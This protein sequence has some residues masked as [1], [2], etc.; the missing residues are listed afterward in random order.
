MLIHV[1]NFTEKAIQALNYINPCLKFPLDIQPNIFNDVDIRTLYWPTHC[2]NPVL[3]QIVL[4]RVRPV[5]RSTVIA[6][7]SFCMKLTNQNYSYLPL[8]AV[9]LSKQ[10]R[11]H[12]HVTQMSRE[13]NTND[14]INYTVWHY[15]NYVE[16]W[17]LS[18]TNVTGRN[19][20]HHYMRNGTSE[21]AV[22]YWYKL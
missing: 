5:D 2:F 9:K 6:K 21:T 8:T 22:Q 13:E 14:S 17:P 1:E 15:F 16:P 18:P 7:Y 3:L 4:R 10:S 12:Y 19:L 11:Q 20:L